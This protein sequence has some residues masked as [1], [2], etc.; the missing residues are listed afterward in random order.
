MGIPSYFSYIIKNYSKI[1]KKLE[2]NNVQ[3]THFYLD[4]NSI[5][6]DVIKNL[7]K[8]DKTINN[9][10][11]IQNVISQI[12]LYIKRISPTNL[13]YIAFDGVAP[14]AKLEQQRQRRFKS[15]YQK[16][17]MNS[18]QKTKNKWDTCQI[19]PGTQFMNELNY[20]T[21]KYFQEN[22]TFN[23]TEIIVSTSNEVGEGEH[24]IFD[25]IRTSSLKEHNEKKINIIYGLDADLIMLCLNHLYIGDSIYLYRETPEFIKSIQD[26]LEPNQEYLIDIYLLS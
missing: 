19:T 11:I 8:D 21:N 14:I 26:D 10:I 12:C 6:Y 1:V 24:K 17:I 15:Y 13:V 4:C 2:E 22:N 7:E 20:E 25:Y 16:Q 9:K 23:V 3:P 18:I 5:I